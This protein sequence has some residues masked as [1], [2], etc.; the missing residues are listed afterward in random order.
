MLVVAPSGSARLLLAENYAIPF[1]E[2]GRPHVAREW[3]VPGDG[4]GRVAD[5]GNYDRHLVALEFR[6]AG[7]LERPASAR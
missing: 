4:A 3:A 2:G 1:D 7:H 5:C 6:L